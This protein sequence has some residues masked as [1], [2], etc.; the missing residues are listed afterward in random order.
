MNSKHTPRSS[1]T[2]PTRATGLPVRTRLKA[3]YSECPGNTPHSFTSG[4]PLS[5]RSGY[6]GTMGDLTD[7]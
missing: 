4:L 3:G 5:P 6:S 7:I 1:D 2:S